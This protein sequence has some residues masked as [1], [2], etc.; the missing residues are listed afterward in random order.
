[1]QFFNN[2]RPHQGLGGHV[3][4]QRLLGGLLRHYF[5]DAA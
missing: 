2:H 3:G 4:C 1:M 5:R